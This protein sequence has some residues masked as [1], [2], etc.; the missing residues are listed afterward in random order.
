MCKP[1]NTKPGWFRQVLLIVLV[2]FEGVSSV[3]RPLL[4]RSV[5]CLHQT[6]KGGSEAS[7]IGFCRHEIMT[8]ET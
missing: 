8:I 4:I 6:A 5:K 2:L 1:T 3:T 7:F